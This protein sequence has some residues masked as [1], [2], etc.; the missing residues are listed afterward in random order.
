MDDRRFDKLARTIGQGRTRRHL[1]AGLLGT[2]GALA[3][4]R[5]EGA[6]RPAGNPQPRTCPGN[7]YWNGTTCLCPA[8]TTKCGS[9]C[10]P[11]GQSVCCDGACCQGECY[12]EEL[13]CEAGSSVC[14]GA[15]CCAAEE[16]C[17]TDGGCCTPR[18]CGAEPPASLHGCGSGTDGC[19]NPL[20][21]SCPENWLCLEGSTGTFCAN[22]TNACIPGITAAN[23]GDIGLCVQGTGFCADSYPTQTTRCVSLTPVSC[24]ACTTD[25]ECGAGNVCVASWDDVCPSSTM[26]ATPL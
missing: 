12:G 24:S 1:L 21:C 26:C 9:D 18:T 22:L 2:G 16:I 14:H 11:N 7:Q 10:C 5:V 23:Y 6:R 15:A 4:R 17:L 3:T 8:G 19:G 20:V 13:C 25:A